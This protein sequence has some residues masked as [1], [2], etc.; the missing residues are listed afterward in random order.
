MSSKEFLQ[1]C[2]AFGCNWS[3]M[4]LSGIKHH[5]PEYYAQMPDDKEYD[6]NE[7]INITIELG[8]DW[9]D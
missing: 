3:A 9:G 1:G 2:N 7:L 4:I 6:F 5:F 8:V